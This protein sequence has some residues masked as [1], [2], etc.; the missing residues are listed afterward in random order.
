MNFNFCRK[1]KE[2]LRSKLA[3]KCWS[4][5]RLYVDL[6]RFPEQAQG[7]PGSGFICLVSEIRIWS[8]YHHLTELFLH[9]TSA[10]AATKLKKLDI[11]NSDYINPRLLANVVPWLE[12]FRVGGGGGTSAMFNLLGS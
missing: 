11:H 8:C 7:L 10:E 6:Y 1:W 3:A 2:Y 4:G 9:L 5:A 12:T